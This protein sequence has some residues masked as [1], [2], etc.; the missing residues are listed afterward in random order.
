MATFNDKISNLL[1]SQVPDFVLEDHPLCV[2]FVKAYYSFLESAEIKLKTISKKPEEL[3]DEI[4]NYMKKN[5]I[6]KESLIRFDLEIE[7]PSLLI[8]RGI[9]VLTY[10]PSLSLLF[11]NS[12]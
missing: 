12:I 11:L 5:N 2:D 4:L 6:T 9:F 3:A 10:I 8:L 1:N 7:N